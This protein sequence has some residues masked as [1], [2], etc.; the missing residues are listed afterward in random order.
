VDSRQVSRATSEKVFPRPRR[1]PIR[2]GGA[3]KRALP[4]EA[5]HATE[6]RGHMAAASRIFRTSAFNRKRSADKEHR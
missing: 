5:F 4:A 6:G 3:E 2:P 1:V